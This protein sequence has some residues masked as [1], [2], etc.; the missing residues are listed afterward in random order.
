MAGEGGRFDR[1]LARFNR[2]GTNRLQRLWA[3]YVPPYALIV[4]RGRT[5]GRVYRTPVTA[6][7]RQGTL[8]V[9]LPYGVDSDWVKNLLAAQGGEVVRR[10]RTSALS[11]P[12]VVSRDDGPKVPIL[13]RISPYTF[14]ADVG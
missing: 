13:A 3:P 7:V 4:H 10:G 14:V 12:R 11:N 1:G 6:F 8:I 9:A 5:S 2:V